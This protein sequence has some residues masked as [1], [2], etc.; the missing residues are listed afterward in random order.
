[1]TFGIPLYL[2]SLASASPNVL[3]TANRPGS[4]LN[5]PVICSIFLLPF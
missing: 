3:E 1:M 5:G 2:G 4:T